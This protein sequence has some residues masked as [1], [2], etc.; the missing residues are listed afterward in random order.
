MNYA[1]IRRSP[2]VDTVASS[3]GSKDVAFCPLVDLNP[4][5][6]TTIIRVVAVRLIMMTQSHPLW[7]TQKKKL[8]F[9]KPFDI[10]LNEN[11][12]R[13]CRIVYYTTHP[14][15]DHGLRGP[16]Q[17]YNRRSTISTIAH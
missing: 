11:P 1:T 16:L 9:G 10:A 17:R 3:R 6:C 13:Y 14:W 7:S 2:S 12:F 15:H 4:T 5:K 8:P